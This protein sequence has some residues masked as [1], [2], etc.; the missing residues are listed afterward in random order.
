MQSCSISH[1]VS[2]MMSHSGQI[3]VL[4]P[5]HGDCSMLQHLYSVLFL[6]FCL[7]DVT[8]FSAAALTHGGW[9][10][11]LRNWSFSFVTCTI[12][13]KVQR[14]AIVHVLF[15]CRHKF[16]M[17]FT[18]LLPLKDHSVLLLFAR[19]R[20]DGYCCQIGGKE[21]TGCKIR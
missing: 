9:G 20:L 12:R 4:K 7:D 11:T 6:I 18:P 15:S 21:G 1:R 5:L 14:A 2:G 3:T 8:L 16:F 19:A 13:S 17:L 10:R